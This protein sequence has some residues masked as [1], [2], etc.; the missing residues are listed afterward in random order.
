MYDFVSQF[1]QLKEGGCGAVGNCPFHDDDHP[2][3]GVNWI[4]N[5]WHC[6]AGCGGGTVIDFYMKWK[7]VDFFTATKELAETLGLDDG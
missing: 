2:S 7:D 3:F 1:V 5:Y 6:F 4:D